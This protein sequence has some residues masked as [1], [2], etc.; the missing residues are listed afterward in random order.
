MD[1]LS[2]LAQTTG[3]DPAT[4]GSFAGWQWLL[5]A[6]SDA[7]LHNNVLLFGLANGSAAPTCVAKICRSPEAS[8]VIEKEYSNLTTLWQALGDEAAGRAPRPLGLHRHGRDLVF[9][10]AYCPGRSW[11][12]E[13]RSLW[14]DERRLRDRFGR[15]ARALRELHDRTATAGQPSITSSVFRAQANAFQALYRPPAGEV[16]ELARLQ[17]VVGQRQSDV[18][19]HILLQGDFWPGNIVVNTQ[20]GRLA[21]V[22]WQ[23]ARWSPDASQDVYLFILAAAVEA[24]PPG[25]PG[26]RALAAADLLASWSRVLIPTYLEAY[27]QP[28]GY[29]LLPLRDGL[30]ATCVEMATR[31]YLTFGVQQEDGLLWRALFAELRLW[32]GTQT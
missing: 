14:R 5:V 17:T 21:V 20:T 7:G 27:G 12:T 11:L 22:D 30:L 28:A 3:C 29:A 8:W 15:A 32:P 6:N 9:L 26:Q 10:M 2:E 24:A 18:R 13:R 25:S 4:S 16:A 19:R 1:Y 23:A 31:P